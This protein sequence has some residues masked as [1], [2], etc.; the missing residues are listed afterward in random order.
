M[1]RDEIEQT[2]WAAQLW[3]KTTPSSYREIIKRMAIQAPVFVVWNGTGTEITIGSYT[4]HSTATMVEAIEWCQQFELPVRTQHPDIT[5]ELV[6]WLGDMG[7][8]K[9]LPVGERIAYLNVLV[10][11][12]EL[13][14]EAK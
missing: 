5:R 1:T 2:E 6:Q 3:K 12:N 7:N 14:R 13:M 9:I 4:I 11:I 10:K 8:D